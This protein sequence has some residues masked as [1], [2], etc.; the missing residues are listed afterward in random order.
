MCDLFKNIFNIVA[1]VGGTLLE[2]M[3]SEQ[4]MR[5]AESLDTTDRKA[6]AK[7]KIALRIARS[8]DK[9]RWLEGILKL[10]FNENK[11]FLSSESMS[12]A[13]SKQEMNGI[14]CE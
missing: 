5:L 3:H 6:F 9:R 8:R 2:D 11:N 12:A 1:D 4:H 13:S 7:E 14:S 10:H